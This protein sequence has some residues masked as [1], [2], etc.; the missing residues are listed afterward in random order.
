MAR[1]DHMIVTYSGVHREVDIADTGLIA[2]VGEPID[3][4]FEIATQLLAQTSWT[5]T[6][7]KKGDA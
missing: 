1:A 5:T 6:N 2:K 4:P 3:V 7:T